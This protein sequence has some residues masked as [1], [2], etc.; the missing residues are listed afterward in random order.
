MRERV[1]KLWRWGALAVAMSLLVAAGFLWGRSDP[2]AR[3]ARLIGT[4][5]AIAQGTV[6]APADDAA[7]LVAPVSDV[8][9]MD[10]EAKRFYRYDKDRNGTINRDEYFMAR[11]KA[12]A[13]L[14]T[15]GDGKLSFE[16]YS[17]KAIAKFN[18]ADA[19]RDGLLTAKEFATTAI[20]HK[21]RN[22]PV[23]PP[24]VI[25]AAAAEGEN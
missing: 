17:V 4:S 23:C 5:A 15:N 13:K 7:P 2:H 14:D 16:E 20:V 24:G 12:F 6:P 11:H 22:K 1:L 21:P 8:T 19:N 10:K 9:P 18:G 3:A 25:A